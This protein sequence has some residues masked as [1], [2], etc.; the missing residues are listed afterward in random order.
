MRFH[1][2]A[3]GIK[4]KKGTKRADKSNAIDMLCSG[5]VPASGVEREEWERHFEEVPAIF[6]PEER[7]EWYVL[8]RF[9]FAYA[10]SRPANLATG[11]QTSP[12]SPARAMPSSRS[13]TTSTVLGA[14]ALSTSR[15]PL[16][17]KT[18]SRASRPRVSLESALLSSRSGCSTIRGR[19]YL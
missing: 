11:F 6:T 1:E 19:A 17:A 18:T 2:R 7:K 3:I 9:K 13:P 5:V 4:W 15:R 12:R 14:P 16:A 8:I 10:L